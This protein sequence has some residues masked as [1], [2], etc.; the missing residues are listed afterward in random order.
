MEVNNA[1]IDKLSELSRLRFEGPE[2]EAIKG[3]LSRMLQFIDT[4]NEVDTSTVEP[5]VYVNEEPLVLR[6]DTVANELSQAD[7]LRNAPD[8]DS[9]YIRVP[10]VVDK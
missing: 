4:L 9:D 5:L 6:P 3:D 1:L 8:H 2:R 7:A 10:K